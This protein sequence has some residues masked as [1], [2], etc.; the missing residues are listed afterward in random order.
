MATPCPTV[1]VPRWPGASDSLLPVAAGVTSVTPRV[2]LFLIDDHPLFRGGLSEALGRE[3]EIVGDAGDV[4]AAVSGIA[5]TLPD[6][7]LLDVFMADGGG[8]AVLEAVARRVANPPRFLAISASVEPEDVIGV[9]RAGAHSYVTKTAHPED[10]ARAINSVH[11]GAAVFSP[12]VAGVV[13]GALRAELPAA[14]DPE[15]EY[16]T[17]RKREVLIYIA[18]ELPY[19]EIAARL[20]LSVRTVETHVSTLLRKLE[21]VSRHE[22]TRWAINHRLIEKGATR[23]S[24]G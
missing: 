17:P 7:V 6:V 4:D 11:E 19:K 21:L 8:I 14:I 22:L 15:L 10:L 12:A 23:H 5:A 13:L 1:A 3:F 2:R 18:H 20:H 16:L 9:I 24:C